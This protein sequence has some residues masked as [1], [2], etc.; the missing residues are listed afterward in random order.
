MGTVYSIFMSVIL[1]VH[2][3][4]YLRYLRIYVFFYPLQ[5][6]KAW[7]PSSS[8]FIT[9]TEHL[10]ITLSSALR[11]ITWATGDRPI[12]PV[13]SSVTSATICA[14]HR[15]SSDAKNSAQKT[16]LAYVWIKQWIFFLSIRSFELI[17]GAIVL[18]LHPCLAP[19]LTAGA[20][21]SVWHSNSQ[22][23]ILRNYSA[24][25]VQF[26]YL[27][28]IWFWMSFNQVKSVV[29]VADQKKR[30]TS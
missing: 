7:R 26:T 23:I 29:H 21:F 9:D 22:Y 13:Y 1:R 28:D 10:R 15:H 30:P 5:A 20:P 4:R 19:V 25:C 6:A 3:L 27:N 24:R 18:N 12:L 11:S 16:R 14:I 17:E 8:Y 2:H